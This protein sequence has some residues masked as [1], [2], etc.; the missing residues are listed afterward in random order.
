MKGRDFLALTVGFNLLGGILAGLLVGYA[1]DRWFME[2]LFKVKSFPF[3][4][5]FF[6]F[7]G[8]VSGFWNA[9]RDLRRL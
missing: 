1:F 9:Y 6:F 3:G 8:I 5:I 7:I 2:G 4:L